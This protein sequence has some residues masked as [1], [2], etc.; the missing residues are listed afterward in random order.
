MWNLFSMKCCWQPFDE[1]IL[2]S[3]QRSD[4]VQQ[5]GMSSFRVSSYLYF[6]VSSDV[7]AYGEREGES[8]NDVIFSY[9]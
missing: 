5:G 2:I 9:F 4:P 1:F 3:D 7:L 8:F 6:A